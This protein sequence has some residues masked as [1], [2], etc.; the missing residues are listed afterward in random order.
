MKQFVQRLNSQHVESIFKLTLLLLR[1]D[2]VPEKV[3]GDRDEDKYQHTDGI[4]LSRH[5]I[6]ADIPKC[7]ANWLIYS[8][9]GSEEAAS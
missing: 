9:A 3:Y 5:R 1:G 6:P 4:K 7:Q 8:K 2:E